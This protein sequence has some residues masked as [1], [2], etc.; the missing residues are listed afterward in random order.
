MTSQEK[1]D[2]TEKNILSKESHSSNGTK[3]FFG[4]LILLA[5]GL[6]YGIWKQDSYIRDSCRFTGLV[7][8]DNQADQRN[9]NLDALSMLKSRKNESKYS[10]KS[11]TKYKYRCNDGKIIWSSVI[12]PKSK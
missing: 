11:S 6:F 4:L 2:N 12:S 9:K 7:K 8:S 1:I 10:S 5:V 3:L